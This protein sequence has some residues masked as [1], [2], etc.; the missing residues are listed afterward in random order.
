[1]SVMKLNM[2]HVTQWYS[3]TRGEILALEDFNMSV[4]TGEAIAILGPSGCGKSTCLLAAAGLRAVT[5][6]TDI[7]RS[8]LRDLCNLHYTQPSL[9]WSN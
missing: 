1:M 5:E 9:V 2:S 4:Q 8:K 7:G 3:G 6:G